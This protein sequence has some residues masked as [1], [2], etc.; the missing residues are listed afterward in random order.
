MGATAAWDI[1][2]YSAGDRL[3]VRHT[4]VYLSSPLSS[5]VCLSWFVLG[6]WHGARV[7]SPDAELALS[8]QPWREPCDGDWDIASDAGY[9]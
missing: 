1:H 9:R 4:N 3:G 7:I 8:V 2:G 5:N 6:D